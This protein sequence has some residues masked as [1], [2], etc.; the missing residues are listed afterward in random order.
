M[1]S[2]TASQSR[3]PTGQVRA[4]IARAAL[5]PPVPIVL[6]VLSLI[7]PMEFSVE[8]STL[9]FPPHRFV[10]LLM[11][12]FALARLFSH[13]GTRIQAF[14]VI[15]AMFAT[16]Q[17]ATYTYHSGL[18]GFIFGGSLA[19]EIMGGYFIAR[20]YIRDLETFK[21]TLNFLLGC[22][23]L[24]AAI[25]ITDMLSGRY[26]LHEILSSIVGGP[27]RGGAEFRGGLVRATSTFNHPIHYGGFCAATFALIWCSA[28]RSTQRY[29]RAGFVAFATVLSMSS[30]PMLSI[31]LQ[32]VMLSWERFTRRIAMRVHITLAIVAGLYIGMSFVSSRGPLMLF[33]TSM[34]FDPWTGIYRTFIWHHG[35]NNVWEN[36]YFGLGLADW[37]R[38][39]WMASSTI[40]AYWLV[41]AMRSGIPAFL[42]LALAIYLIGRAVVRKSSRSKDNE[43]RRLATGWMISL[44]ALCLIGSTVH[45]WD[46][47]H[48][49]LFFFIGLGGALADPKRVKAKVA[50]PA[51][52]A[53]IEPNFGYA[54]A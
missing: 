12:P 35:L 43:R 26:L 31:G 15:M 2:T 5:W 21:A 25:A 8:I 27:P 54:A 33:I 29:A 34:T 28:S 3:R 44:I 13:P 40:D 42:M 41:L 4:K 10:F 52:P 49:M 48:A 14:D 30:A 16:W 24:V 6:V 51:A 22:I 37:T 23:A 7:C 50:K 17:C 46:M 1:V 18:E 47:P 32:V 9:R 36:P 20:A 11:L 45:F 19:L 39:A 53:R 38:D